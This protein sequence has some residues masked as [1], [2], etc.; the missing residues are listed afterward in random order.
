MRWFKA[1]HQYQSKAYTPQ[2]GDI[3]WYDWNGDGKADHI[4]FVE[5]AEGGKIYTIE[6]NSGGMCRRRTRAANSS[7]IMGYGVPKY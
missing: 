4:G 1:K 5:K 6:G 7:L 3:I 2:P